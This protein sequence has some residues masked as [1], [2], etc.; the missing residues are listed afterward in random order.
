MNFIQFSINLFFQ[1]LWANTSS[2]Y[3][4]VF[5]RNLSK[6][7]HSIFHL[8][9]DLYKG[10]FIVH[11]LMVNIQKPHVFV[12]NQILAFHISQLLG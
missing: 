1:N 8:G 11:Q 5:I 2:N 9:C 3:A 7:F 4:L 6:F 10:K 12:L